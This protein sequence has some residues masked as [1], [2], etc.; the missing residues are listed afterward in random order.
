MCDGRSL[1]RVV[2]AKLFEIVGT[3]F[4]ST[5]STTFNLPDYR[6]RVMG[7]VGQG[8][9][10][11]ARAMGVSVGE[12]T[13]T[14]TANEMPSHTHTGYTEYD[15]VH[16]HS[17]TAAVNGGHNHGGSTGSGGVHTHTSNAVGGSLGLVTADTYDTGTTA[18][19]EG[20][21][22]E[23]NIFKAPTALTINDSTSHTHY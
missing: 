5:S 11:T 4:G 8:S 1:D 15:G 6:G 17:A 16:T 12:E 23:L 18:D 2:Y 9:G 22:G 3:S 14:L 13:H 21:A 7:A 10:L 20:P 19:D